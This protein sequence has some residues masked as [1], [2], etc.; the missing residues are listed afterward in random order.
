MEYFLKY[1]VKDDKSFLNN[2][3][4][5]DK[6]VLDKE[7]INVFREKNNFPKEMPKPIELSKLTKY[8]S[9]LWRKKN[10]TKTNGN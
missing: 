2:D 9:I 3:I 4:E 6:L 1:V 7:V 10:K 5:K 8:Y